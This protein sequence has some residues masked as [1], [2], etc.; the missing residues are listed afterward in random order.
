MGRSARRFYAD[1]LRDLC[2]ARV[3]EKDRH[4]PRRAAPKTNWHTRAP[5]HRKDARPS[6]SLGIVRQGRGRM[7]RPA[8]LTRRD[9]NR[10]VK[11]WHVIDAVVTA[12]AR[13]A[14]EYGLMEAGACGTETV[15][16]TNGQ[17]NVLAYFDCATDVHTARAELVEALRIY[18]CQPASLVE[19][20]TREIEDEDW[21]AEWKKHWQPVEVGRFIIA[22][23]WSEPPA[24]AG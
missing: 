24:V 19:L 12:D 8:A 17:V 5:G 10:T 21:L 15:A 11:T 23:P 13:E 3:A 18:G 16:G 9:G 6:V 7:A 22:P 2:R 4:R 20:K 14:A 1:L